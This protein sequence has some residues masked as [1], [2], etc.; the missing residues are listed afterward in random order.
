LNDLFTFVANK[1]RRALPSKRRSRAP[2]VP[3]IDPLAMWRRLPPETAEYLGAMAIAFFVAAEG[4]HAHDGNDPLFDMFENV[5][6]ESNQQ[7]G[8]FLH[9]YFPRAFIAGNGR[10]FPRL[11]DLSTLKKSNRSETGS[12]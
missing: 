9:L 6:R 1:N 12:A 4:M 5:M 7:L 3:L 11:P 8:D 2:K 10:I